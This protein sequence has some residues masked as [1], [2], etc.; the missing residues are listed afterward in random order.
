MQLI[1]IGDKPF[2]EQYLWDVSDMIRDTLPD[3]RGRVN[4]C[5]AQT[6]RKAALSTLEDCMEVVDMMVSAIRNY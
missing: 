3:F 2:T 1:D 4:Y 5:L 6:S